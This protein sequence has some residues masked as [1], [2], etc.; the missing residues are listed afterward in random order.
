VR[1]RRAYRPSWRMGLTGHFGIGQI[2]YSYQFM[3]GTRPKNRTYEG[4]S[5]LKGLTLTGEYTHGAFGMGLRVGF[6]HIFYWASTS[7]ITYNYYLCPTGEPCEWVVDEEVT[8]ARDVLPNLR[9]VVGPQLSWLPRVGK[10]LRL[11]PVFSPGFLLYRD[12]HY[13]PDVVS[14]T[15]YRLGRQFAWE[16]GLQMLLE[17]AGGTS[18]VLGAS[19]YQSD[20]QPEGYFEAVR[21]EGLKVSHLGMRFSVGIGLWK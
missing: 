6:D 21:A 1:G 4:P 15:R 12:A 16:A 14:D 19:A 10:D 17:N 9:L 13:Q 2:D 7:L 8:R 18:L 5:N 20:F 3:D 11:G